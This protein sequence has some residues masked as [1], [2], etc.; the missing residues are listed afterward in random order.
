MIVNG[1]KVVFN[2]SFDRHTEEGI[3]IATRTRPNGTQEKYQTS[4][5]DSIQMFANMLKSK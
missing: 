4:S 1:F 2:K 5:E 3:L